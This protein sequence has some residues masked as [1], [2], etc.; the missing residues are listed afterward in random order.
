MFG[1][2]EQKKQIEEQKQ[3]QQQ[4]L[5]Y[6][7]ALR[8]KVELKTEKSAIISMNQLMNVVKTQIS[9]SKEFE[10]QIKI[11][12]QEKAEI[13]SSLESLSKCKE[14][15]IDGFKAR[16]KGILFQNGRN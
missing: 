1:N 6:L 2:K 15:D 8:T 9:L 14:H 12:Q 13:L 16:L 5:E 10:R 3:K 11:L 4:E 7:L